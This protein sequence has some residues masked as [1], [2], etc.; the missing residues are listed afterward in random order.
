MFKS[1]LIALA[2]VASC[3]CAVSP[4]YAQFGSLGGMVG[5]A[6]GDSGGAPVDVDGFIKSAQ[7]AE[8]LMNNSVRLLSRSLT[9]KE[10]AADLDAQRAAAN[11]ITDS[12]ERD[13]KL[14][15]V[16]K[17][18][19]AAINEA[20]SNNNLA[21]DI[22]KMDAKQREDIAAGAFN[23]ML[24]LL[25]DKA[26]VDQAKGII[27]SISTNPM[28]VSKLGG[29]KDVATSL[30]NQISDAGALAGKMPAIFTAVGVKAPAS[31][32]EK[33]KVTKSTSE[34]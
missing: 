16:N 31:K 29:V 23:F 30:G 18:S 7:T 24:A 33:P 32:D 19:L 28:M 17:N 15:E 20:A 10:K 11:A 8:K 4:A 2:V 12:K 5:A 26:L 14:L 3:A 34:E 1:K 22:K 6:K 27:A 9:S 25:Q 13:A 21:A